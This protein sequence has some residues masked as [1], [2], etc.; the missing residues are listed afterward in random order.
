MSRQVPMVGKDDRAAFRTVGE[1]RARARNG[2]VIRVGRDRCPE[3]PAVRARVTGVAGG[4][5]D[6]AELLPGQGS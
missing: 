5:R 2:A 3:S 1:A 6:S 4:G